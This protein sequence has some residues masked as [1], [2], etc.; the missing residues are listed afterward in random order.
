MKA[1]MSDNSILPKELPSLENKNNTYKIIIPTCAY[2]VKEYQKKYITILRKFLLE[3][4]GEIL[5]LDLSN[6][7]GGKTEVIASGLLPLFLLQPS[8]KLILL[9][10][11]KGVK[12]ERVKIVNNEIYNLPVKI[13]KTKSMEKKPQKINVYIG[14]PTGSAAEQITLALTLLKNITDVTFLGNPTA[15]FTT[16]IEYIELPNGGGLE[17]PVG[18]MVSISGI[19]ARSNGRLY[20]S[21]LNI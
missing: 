18:N 12:K 9:E 5:E 3:F 7:I 11:S 8:K 21:D 17:Y 10:N 14:N 2:N 19:K 6:N 20:P 16:W 15:G 1:I 13:K 4:D